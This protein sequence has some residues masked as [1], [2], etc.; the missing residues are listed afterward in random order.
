MAFREISR[1]RAT[2]VTMAMSSSIPASMPSGQDCYCS[3][4][5]IYTDGLRTVIS[6]LIPDG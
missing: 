4:N 6:G 1:E 2:T 5:V 3:N